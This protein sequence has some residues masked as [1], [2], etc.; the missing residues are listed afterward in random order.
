MKKLFIFLIF[1]TFINVMY[2][3]T[4]NQNA[5]SYGGTAVLELPKGQKLINVT[6]KES[7]LWYLIRPMN[8]SDTAIT[9]TFAE[10]SSYGVWEGKYIIK[11]QK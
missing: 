9:Y 7:D 11:E 1:L 4:K 5:K 6:W 2:S 8:V 10:E 3:C